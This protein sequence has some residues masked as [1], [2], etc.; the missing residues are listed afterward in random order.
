[1]KSLGDNKSALNSN[2]NTKKTDSDDKKNENESFKRRKGNHFGIS[3]L[4]LNYNLK[5][6][7]TPK[8]V[9]RNKT[10]K[11]ELFNFHDSKKT[12]NVFSVRKEKG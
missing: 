12:N 6:E 2:I 5:K 11:P 1:M 7:G 3:R 10:I 9:K 8:I 4:K